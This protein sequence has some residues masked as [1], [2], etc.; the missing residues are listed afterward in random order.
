M[1]TQKCPLLYQVVQSL[2]VCFFIKNVSKTNTPHTT[3]HCINAYHTSKYAS[4]HAFKLMFLGNIIAPLKEVSEGTPHSPTMNGSIFPVFFLTFQG[5]RNV[6]FYTISF[7]FALRIGR[8]VCSCRNSCQ[9]LRACPYHSCREQ[10]L[11]K[12]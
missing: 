4:I 2:A 1:F 10:H 11:Q 7:L 9:N 12:L 3:N 5:L 8:F 6:F